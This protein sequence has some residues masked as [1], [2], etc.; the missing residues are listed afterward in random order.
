MR[1]HCIYTV[2]LSGHPDFSTAQCEEARSS[3]AMA[4]NERMTAVKSFA[5]H[6]MLMYSPETWCMGDEM[7]RSDAHY[8]TVSTLKFRMTD[9]CADHFN[10]KT[11]VSN[12]KNDAVS[13]IAHGSRVLSNVAQDGVI[14]ML[15]D[16]LRDGLS[17][18]A[19]QDTCEDADA[20]GAPT[21]PC[22]L[23]AWMPMSCAG[24]WVAV[25]FV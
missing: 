7:F 2:C 24:H 10:G 8:S 17:R 22:S 3:V 13:S 19:S 23:K 1:F 20:V 14:H 11:C 5:T 6:L 25:D 21:C 4:E 15:M 18:I 16:C 9:R 12:R